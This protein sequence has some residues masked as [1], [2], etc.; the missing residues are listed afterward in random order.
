MGKSSRKPGSNAAV[1]HSKRQ[2][3]IIQKV[4]VNA[5]VKHFKRNARALVTM[6][7]GSGKTNVGIRT[8]ARMGR[9]I[10][11]VA[12]PSIGL[13]KQWSAAVYSAKSL[14]G[15]TQLLVCSEIRNGEYVDRP[16][17]YSLPVTTCPKQIMSAMSKASASDRLI[18][19]VT[20]H[21]FQRVVTAA[22]LAAQKDK[23]I[24]VGFLVADEA[25]N[26]AGRKEKRF[27]HCLQDD[28]LKIQHRLFLTATPKV[29]RNLGGDTGVFCMNDHA[30]YGRN[31][32]D[33][34][35]KVAVKKGIISDFEIR[36]MEVNWDGRKDIGI[37][38]EDYLRSNNR[39]VE[40][41]A[42]LAEQMRNNPGMRIFSFHTLCA[43]AQSLNAELKK[44]GVWSQ[45]ITGKMPIPDRD[46]ILNEFESPGES[47]VICSVRVFG[48]GMDVPSVDTIL[49]SDPRFGVQD[50]SQITGRGTRVERGK[51]ILTIYLPIFNPKG[52]DEQRAEQ[53]AKDSYFEA[54]LN[55]IRA[56]ASLDET[57]LSD[58]VRVFSGDGQCGN[59]SDGKRLHVDIPVDLLRIT[60]TIVLSKLKWMPNSL[61]ELSQEFLKTSPVRMPSTSVVDVRGRTVRAWAAFVGHVFGITWVEFA[62]KTWPDSIRETP[63]SLDEFQ[64][65]LRD[66][67]NVRLYIGSDLLVHGRTI[68]Q[69][70]GWIKG[71]AGWDVTWTQVADAAWPDS[72]LAAIDAPK[73]PE[74]LMR[75]MAEASSERLVTAD[76]RLIHG[77]SVYA[78]SVWIIKHSGWGITWP[79]FADETWPE[80]AVQT[81][82]PSSKHE[83]Q[84][85]MREVSDVAIHQGSTIRVKGRTVR[86][87]VRWIER[88][89]GWGIKWKEFAGETWAVLPV[90]KAELQ[91]WMQAA[92]SRRLSSKSQL[93]IHGK[94]VRCWSHWITQ[95][96]G[97]DISWAD[98]SAETWPDDVYEIPASMEE[99]QTWLR[100]ASRVRL[101]CNSADVVHSRTILQWNGWIK[102]VSGWGVTWR[103]FADATWPE[104]DTKS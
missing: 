23:S 59:E 71:V 65:W 18:I 8:I 100:D 50:I 80:S 12:V 53:I 38:D 45:C 102:S 92:S 63:S 94:T 5:V 21:S 61:L 26:T 73:S 14:D 88:K 101:S 39:D 33:L 17:D 4:A 54:F 91:E 60:K 49:I 30:V 28:L 22:K 3:T 7:C 35:F 29:A 70:V 82:V 81:F 89:S 99:L 19:I 95:Y 41:A 25:H 57:L 37:N 93:L 66:S 16:E 20:Y 87:W 1:K 64:R 43:N 44:Q 32:Y 56:L 76:N 42:F 31:V 75:W 10:S 46:V 40:I 24:T 96:S 85:W 11:V 34:P 104:S 6:A 79:E 74:E 51:K 86:S 90:S 2:K 13:V 15:S 97:W 77:R 72:A 103:Q 78:W 58:A 67:S 83:L 55:T 9:S 48:E 36:A 47:R 69:W 98:F 52:T 68:Q 62:D 84:L 27:A